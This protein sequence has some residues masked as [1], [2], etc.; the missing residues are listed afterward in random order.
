MT[1]NLSVA[2]IVT[3]SNA[4]FATSNFTVLG[5]STVGSNTN[6][7]FPLY[8]QGV[9]SDTS[10]ISIKADGDVSCASDARLKTDLLP[11]SHALA[12]VL[13]IGGYTYRRLG[14][15]PAASRSAGVLAQE[16][17]GVL[18]EVVGADADGMMHVAYGNLAALLIEAVKELGG[19]RPLSLSLTTSEPDEPFEMPL[20][21]GRAWSAALIS[22]A[23]GYSRCHAAISVDR[24]AVVGRCERPGLFTVLALVE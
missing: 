4:V 11:I 23:D 9:A 5:R 6:T 16:V 17:M 20:P 15:H 3:L 22:S 1:S 12:K 24:R 2:G 13:S 21:S 18:P 14:A 7:V 10:G 8:V 19:A